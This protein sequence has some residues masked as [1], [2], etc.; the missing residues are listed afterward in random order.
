MKLF[1][2]NLG[3]S[4][5]QTDLEYLVGKLDLEG[6]GIAASPEESDAIII[7]TCGFIEPAVTEA[8]DHILEFEPYQKEG[9]KLIV[10][11]CMVER[12][13]D[14]FDKEFPNVDF[15]T[16]VG[17]LE[18]IV[19]YLKGQTVDENA[20]RSF[21]GEQRV[22]LNVPYFAYLK[23][24]EGC[25]NRCSYCKI[26]S[27]RGNLMSRPMEEIVAEAKNLVDQGVK[28]II[29]ISQD[30]TK[31]GS[32]LYGKPRLKALLKSLTAIEG[33]FYIRLLYLNPDGVT[34][35]LVDYVAKTD[36]IIKYFEIPVQ[37]ITDPILK[38]MNRKSNAKKIHDI[39]GYIRKTIPTA[40]LRTTFIMGFPG[41]TETDVDAV[42][43]F[44]TEMRPDFAGFFPFYPEDG[45]KA[46]EMD[47]Q[48]KRSVAKKRISRL[49]KIQKKI[50]KDKIKELKKD[51]IICF[52]DKANDDFDFILEG[53]GLFQAP[54][55]D[56][57]AYF[58]D[59]VAD[60]GFGPYRCKIKRV[61]YPDIYCKIIA[62]V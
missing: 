59:G 54:E 45:V 42:E 20:E 38:G 15:Y 46:T 37:H 13:K 57:K 7:N 49:Q 60:N 26:P 2:V 40:T 50:T 10:A 32:D 4:K 29:L 14:D 58:I 56:G 35:S 31:Y 43:D 19:T 21:Y 47:G 27:L 11:G 17:T 30:T 16:G 23:I 44:I 39:F 8:I 55:I 18:N 6:F 62:S 53:R 24:A 36:K 61:V 28:E 22:L 48:V 5:N 52:V 34:E 25:N 12:F 9:K 33:E 3:C 1:F 41:E 51:E